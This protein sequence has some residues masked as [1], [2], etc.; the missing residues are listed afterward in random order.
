M[1]DNNFINFAQQ[2]KDDR[3]EIEDHFVNN[4]KEYGTIYKDDIEPPHNYKDDHRYFGFE[5]KSLMY[6]LENDER[7]FEDN[8]FLTFE[9]LNE[10]GF[11]VKAGTK[12]IP[13][14]QFTQDDK[15]TKEPFDYQAVKASGVNVEEYKKENVNS[16]YKKTYVFNGEDIEGMP[17]KINYP[18][19]TQEEYDKIEQSLYRS[20]ADSKVDNDVAKNLFMS[21]KKKELNYFDQYEQTNAESVKAWAKNKSPEEIQSTLNGVEAIEKSWNKTADKEIVEKY[22]KATI[23]DEIENTLDRSYFRDNLSMYISKEKY[24]EMVAEIVDKIRE[25]KNAGIK[26]QATKQAYKTLENAENKTQEGAKEEVE[27]SAKEPI[28][29]EEKSSIK[30]D[31][32]EKA[33]KEIF[34]EKD[35][36][37]KAEKEHQKFFKT[38][39]INKESKEE[40]K[41][42]N[43]N[44]KGF[45]AQ[46][47]PIKNI[48]VVDG[49]KIELPK[50]FDK[51]VAQVK[52]KTQEKEIER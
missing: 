47:K 3:K 38:E 50:D 1:A 15:K 12:G 4:V 43:L 36:N 40:K 14:Y 48:P 25:E 51:E 52:E 24:D 6:S 29:D 42:L 28:K 21:S 35:L 18:E 41:T 17:P 44:T 23:Y 22:E 19:K 7:N 31:K 20:V 49:S 30:E 33:H 32:N 34:K 26:E 9:D 27:P 11:R 39:E 5:K 2:Y 13:F 8:R 45:K 16:Y 10:M 37:S 46:I